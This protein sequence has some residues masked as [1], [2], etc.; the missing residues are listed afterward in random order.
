M[1]A[2]EVT[3]WG[4]TQAVTILWAEM[5]HFFPNV[6]SCVLRPALAD[7]PKQDSGPISAASRS[8]NSAGR[9]SLQA[10]SDQLRWV[11][12]SKRMETSVSGAI[13][14]TNPYEQRAL[15]TSASNIRHPDHPAATIQEIVPLIFI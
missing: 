6:S 12:L 7:E 11:T 8:P 14:F 3:L 9:K 2:K 4:R 10:C 15:A 5:P 1:M 13:D